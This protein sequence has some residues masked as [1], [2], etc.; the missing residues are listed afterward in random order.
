MLSA[1]GIGA[2]E[3]LTKPAAAPASRY[4][5]APSAAVQKPTVGRHS[6]VAFGNVKAADSI[7]IGPAAFADELAP[8][9]RLRASQGFTPLFVDVQ[10]I[11]DVF[12]DGQLS[13]VA[14]RNF[15]R[16]ES[17]W[18]NRSRKI[19]VVLAGDATIDPFAYG[20]VPNQTLVAAWMDD[21]DPYQGAGGNDGEAACDACIAQLDGDDPV[22]GDNQ[23][24]GKGWFAADVWIGR[25]P[26]RSEEETADMVA[27]LVNYD[28]ATD[29][30]LW[31][32][33]KVF[34]ADNYI[35]ALDAQQNARPDEAGDF[36]ALS[37]AIVNMLPNPASSRRIYYDPAP[38]RRMTST[39]ASG[40][41][42]QT[43]ERT[44]R[45]NWRIK[46]IVGINANVMPETPQQKVLGNTSSA[47]CVAAA[48][49]RIRSI[50]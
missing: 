27:K 38:T 32:G 12:S 39:P 4:L 1:A 46:D 8:L 2:G 40:G 42:Y 14:I 19:S 36:A 34:L 9:L 43:V 10:A 37:D 16:Q 3:P 24:V 29:G 25:L 23:G 7:Y 45:E 28:L 50:I 41:Y 15:L 13:A 20:G 35:K 47:D 44:L 48:A 33:R 30:G 22:I 49:Q 26:V 31:R 18:Q 21:V 5:L 11:Y 17:D 6:A